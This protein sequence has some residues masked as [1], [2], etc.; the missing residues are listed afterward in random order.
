MS[1]P[2]SHDGDTRNEDAEFI[3]RWLASRD[4]PCP[5]C[6]YNL[7]GVASDKCPECGTQLSLHLIAGDVFVPYRS[8]WIVAVLGIAVPL[9]P[10]I[11]LATVD[12]RFS[13]RVPTFELWIVTACLVTALVALF[14]R[15]K[16]FGS[17][18]RR[19]QWRT[20]V[21]VCVLMSLLL[22]ILLK[23]QSLRLPMRSLANW[24]AE[25]GRLFIRG[26]E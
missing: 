24:L 13:S 26:T 1:K 4:M 11:T 19:W 10:I 15:R 9:G 17:K 2:E 20:A 25:V 12:L 16:W 23:Y 21:S 5:A 22:A 14:A 6:S 18:R 7:H 8:A 3:A